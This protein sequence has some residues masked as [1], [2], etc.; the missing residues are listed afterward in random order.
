MEQKPIMSINV[1]QWSLVLANR[2]Q[3]SWKSSE[4][5]KCEIQ[6]CKTK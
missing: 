6:Q 1:V 2:P 5:H 4:K 3:P